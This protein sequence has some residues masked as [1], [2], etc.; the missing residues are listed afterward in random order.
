MASLK[1]EERGRDWFGKGKEETGDRLLFQS[2]LVAF[3]SAA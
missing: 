1:R 2:F 3:E